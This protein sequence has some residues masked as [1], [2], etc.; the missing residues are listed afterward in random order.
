MIC[1]ISLSSLSPAEAADCNYSF[2]LPSGG[3]TWRVNTSQVISWNRLG[4]CSHNVNL[5]LLRSGVEI[6]SIATGVSNTGSYT[7]NIPSSISP[8]RD[9]AIRIRDQDDSASYAT[10]SEV[11]ITDISGCTFD[12]TRPAAGDTYY[13][14]EEIEVHWDTRGSCSFS[15]RLDLYRSGGYVLEIS[16]NTRNNGV[17]KGIIPGEFAT[18]S[19]YS[20]RVSDFDNS[21]IWDASGSFSIAPAR[22]CSYEVTEPSDGDTWYPGE[23]RMIRY[24][25]LGACSSTVRIALMRGGEKLLTISSGAENNGEYEWELPADL[26]S[27][28]DYRIRV[29]DGADDQIESFSA[30]FSIVDDSGPAHIYWIDN[31]ARLAGAEGSIWRSDVVLLNPGEVDASIELWFFSSSGAHPMESSLRAGTQA[32][33]EDVVGLIGVD[34]KGCL[35]IASDQPLELSGRIYNLTPDGTF[36]QYIRG[37]EDGE[38]LHAGQSARLLQLRQYTDQFRT[39]FSLTN[40]GTEE[41]EA[42]VRLFDSAGNELKTYTL[43]IGPRQLLQD[44]EPFQRRAGRP[45]LGWGS[46]TVEVI[47]GEGVLLSASVIDS[48]TNDP[49]TIPM[50]PI[51]GNP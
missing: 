51:E 48:R 34:G 15:V 19:G 7:W 29:R 37:W 16:D 30:Y 10:S 44:V 50:L 33:F 42:R 14:E 18:G 40:T 3:E 2:I 41:A 39:N 32:I 4:Q 27:G 20:I 11:S 8:A 43:S 25:S 26:D 13:K 31:V 35:G 36:G 17:W 22:P 49:T 21:S 12:V 24:S 5:E 47:S 23:S 28:D 6:S 1:L 9:Y 45:N 46:A 38:G